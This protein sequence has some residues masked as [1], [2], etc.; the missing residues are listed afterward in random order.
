MLK[1]EKEIEVSSA[2]QGNR[3]LKTGLHKCF[4]R[5]TTFPSLFCRTGAYGGRVQNKLKWKKS[6]F[7]QIVGLL[8]PKKLI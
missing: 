5:K 1:R 7:V 6:L 8:F 4:L 2:I 3:G